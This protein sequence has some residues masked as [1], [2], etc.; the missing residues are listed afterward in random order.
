MNTRRERRVMRAKKA[1]LKRL[2][3]KLDRELRAMLVIDELTAALA[4]H[5]VEITPL[6]RSAT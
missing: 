5:T 3:K 4:T 6:E 2:K 1:H